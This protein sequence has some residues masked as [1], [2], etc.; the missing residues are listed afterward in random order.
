[1]Y[2]T[3][4]R[5]SVHTSGKQYL[6][7]EHDSAGALR[8]IA[9]MYPLAKPQVPGYRYSLPANLGI[10]RWTRRRGDTY[11]EANNVARKVIRVTNDEQVDAE[12]WESIAKMIENIQLSFSW[13]PL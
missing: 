10:R 3:R 2:V 12:V 8:A 1:M 11:F 13:Y 5:P 6:S 4:P 9:E 7:A